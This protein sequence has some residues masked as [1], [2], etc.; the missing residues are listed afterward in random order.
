LPENSTT[1]Q[2]TR[3]SIEN[4][5]GDYQALADLLQRS[6]SENA[7][8]SLYYSPEF[9]QSFLTAP[10][11]GASLEP[12]FYR[13][14]MLVAF[15]AGF[16][17]QV[18]YRG[19]SLN[20]ATNTFLSVL[21]EYKRSGLGIVLWTDLVKRIRSEGF[22][23]M[24]NFCVD[25]EPMNRM[26]EGSCQRLGLP[27]Q[28]IF[29]VRYMSSLLRAADFSA[30]SAPASTLAVDEFLNLARPLVSSLPLARQWSTQEA[31]WQLQ[32]AGAVV[33]HLSNESRLGLLTGYTMSILDEQRTKVLLLEDILWHDLQPDERLQ[34]LR[35]FLSQAVSHGAQMATVPVLG[36]ADLTAFKKLRF[37]PTRRVLHCYL[38]L[39]RDDLPLETLPSMYLDVF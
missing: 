18:V 31:E 10:G 26:I 7:Q 28:R 6:W 25:G 33:A 13:D 14:E 27:L 29:S 11:A 12:S 4:F 16:R 23:G 1:A 30:V 24:I 20:L 19:Q 22:D 3:R 35:Q 36:Y 34:L 21:P 17:R 15:A 8:Q 37:F 9:L 39:F 38:T 2:G 32:R 5:R